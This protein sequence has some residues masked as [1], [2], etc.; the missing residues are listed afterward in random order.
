V[1]STGSVPS[2]SHVDWLGALIPILAG[3]FGVVLLFVSITNFDHVMTRSFEKHKD[4]AGGLGAISSTEIQYRVWMGIVGLMFAAIGW[5]I[6]I[7]VL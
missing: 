3:V 7:S 2:G 1:I 5:G 4:S 6:A